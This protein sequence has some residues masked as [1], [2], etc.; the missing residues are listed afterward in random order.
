VIE[1]DNTQGDL[2]GFKA[3]ERVTLGA[4]GT[5]MAKSQAADLLDIADPNGISLPAQ[6]RD[7]SL[8]DPFAFPFQTIE[9]IV[10]ES[11]RDVTVL[12]HNNFPFSVGRHKG[13][14]APDDDELIRLR[15]PQPLR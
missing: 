6:P 2:G 3:L 15:L 11:D 14:G 1:R 4:P 10:I 12:N 8:G 13:S 7:V 5:T 9:D